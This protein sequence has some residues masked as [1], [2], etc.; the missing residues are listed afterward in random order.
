MRK[1]DSKSLIDFA[2]IRAISYLPKAQRPKHLGRTAIRNEPGAGPKHFQ[3]AGTRSDRCRN[4]PG[5]PLHSR[6]RTAGGHSEDRLHTE[7]QLRRQAP[8]SIDYTLL[9]ERRSG[10]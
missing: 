1:H 2:V 10:P 4:G 6:F 9:A 5:L 8:A 3:D 7:I